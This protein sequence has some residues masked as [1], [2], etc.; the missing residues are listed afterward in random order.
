M[1]ALPPAA[2]VPSEQGNGDAHAPELETNVRPAGVE[3]VTCTLVAFP[4]PRLVTVMVYAAFWPAIREPESVLLIAKSAAAETGFVV[5]LVLFDGNGSGVVEL[6]VA[7]LVMFP[8][9][10]GET[11]YVV[12]IVAVAKGTSVPSE[13]GKGVVQAPLLETNVSPA[14]VGSLTETLCA[15]DGPAFVTL[16]EYVAF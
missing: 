13:H 1:V 14:G 16:M 12:V 9:A 11:A 7:V 5:E 3:S 4:G 15:S 8:V 2:N 10:A 6:T